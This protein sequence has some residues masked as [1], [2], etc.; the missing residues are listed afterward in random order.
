MLDAKKELLLEFTLV[1]FIGISNFM[2]IGNPF[3][4]LALF[5]MY[6]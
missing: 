4:S 2:N 6:P 3:I 5:D 1:S